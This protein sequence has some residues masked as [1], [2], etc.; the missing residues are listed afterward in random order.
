MM[1]DVT[2]REG[3]VKWANMDKRKRRIQLF[4]ERLPGVRTIEVNRA[5]MKC[6]IAT[7]GFAH[8]L[9]DNGHIELVI[10]IPQEI[11]QSLLEQF[12]DKYHEPSVK[13]WR[14]W[15]GIRLE[16]N[17][18]DWEDIEARLVE[19]YRATAPKSLSRQMGS[20]VR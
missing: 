13:T 7:K 12:P 16:V 14:K 17:E 9:E 6:E 8:W 11:Q 18:L 10:K 3:P 19:A 5:N 20:E 1:T 4:V 2:R 15:L